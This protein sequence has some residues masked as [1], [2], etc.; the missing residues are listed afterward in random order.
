MQ[1]DMHFY[2]VYALCRAVGIKPKTAETIA[3]ASQFVDDA[4]DDQ[5]VS[6]SDARGLL[7][8]MTSHRPLDYQN[9]LPGDQWRVWI[10]FHF[11]PGNQPIPFQAN[12]T[13]GLF[14]SKLVC[15]ADSP[16]ARKL[17]KHSLSK[18]SKKFWPHMIGIVAHVYADTFS[19]N[20]FLGLAHHW[21]K[22][23][24]DSIEIISKHSPSI[25]HYIW[26]KFEEFKARFASDFAELVPVGH[27]AVATFPDRPYLKWKFVYETHN[28]NGHEI[29]RDNP[30]IYLEACRKLYDFFSKF[31]RSSPE[32]I[33]DYGPRSWEKIQPVLD[34]LINF[35]A[36]KE[37]RI[38]N[39]KKAIEK[40][41]FNKVEKLDKTIHYDRGLWRPRRAEYQ[42]GD[43]SKIETSDSYQFIQAAKWHLGYVLEELFPKMGIL[44]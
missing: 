40:G 3:Y 8:L 20:G 32:Y 37:E 35:E 22:V 31:S 6:L 30:S 44:T 24:A 16:V 38:A 29:I 13:S 2:C 1:I 42:V 15:R 12:D 21:N 4:I 27:A 9:T 36:P 39:W 43:P 17:V 25:L 10:P 11:L 28:G 14:F 26:T 34:K 7:P 23:E 18:R 41:K 5:A 19:H 33:S